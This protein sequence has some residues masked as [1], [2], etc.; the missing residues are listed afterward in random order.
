MSAEARP[1]AATAAPELLNPDPAGIEASGWRPRLLAKLRGEQ[2]LAQM[3]E[4]GLRAEPPIRVGRRTYFDAAYAWAIEIGA[5]TI[6]ANDVRVVA[7]DAA[8]KRLTGYTEV[9][10]VR[11]GRRCYIGAGTIVLPGAVIGDGAIIGAGSLVRGEI[12]AGTV[13]VGSP[14]RV[15]GEA[16]ELGARHMAEMEGRRRFDLWP[17]RLA[18]DQLA[19]V[20]AELER[21]GRVYLY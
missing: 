16:A 2:T 21:S 12:P 13:A 4:R 6:I 14:A 15:V 1:D 8:V 10:P 18:P 9:R 5:E 11:I 17:D 20:R 7:H 3:R 19:E